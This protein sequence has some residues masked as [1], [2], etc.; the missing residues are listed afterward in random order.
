MERSRTRQIN[1]GIGAALA[2]LLLNAVVSYRNILRLMDNER[3]VSHTHLVLANLE[4]T[5]STLK[6]AET[7]QRGYLLTGNRQ[8]LDP[9]AAAITRVDQEVQILERLTADNS[10]QQQRIRDL[11]QAIDRK[12]ENLEAVITRYDSQGFLAAQQ[13]VQQ[14]RGKQLM[15]D[16]RQQ[17]AAMQAEENQLL[18]RRSQESQASARQTL[19][20]FSLASGLNLLLLALIFYLLRQDR[21]ERDREEAKQQQ[22]LT[23]LQAS[24]ARYRSLVSATS[25]AVWGT[26]A[27]GQVV[28]ELPSW[29]ALTGQSF[30]E[31]Q[32]S[33]WLRVLHPNDR[34]HSAQR[35]QHSLKTKTRYETEQRVRVAD[36]TYRLFQ[37]RGVPVLDREGE[38]REWVGTYTDITERKQAEAEIRQLNATLECRVEERT[39]QLQEA[40]AELEGFAYSVAHDLR[41]PLR[42]MQGL[43]EALLEDYGDR[44]DEMGQEYARQIVRSAEQLEDL[45]QDLLAYSRLSRMELQLEPVDLNAAVAESIAQATADADSQPA[46]III[47][48]P[49]PTVTA[50]R[51]TLIQVITNLL[52]NAI[53]FVNRQQPLVRVWAEAIEPPD[54][55]EGIHWVRLWVADNGIGIAPE[56]HKRIF[57]VFERL[58]GIEAY[59]G[60]GIGLAIVQ[61]GVERMGGEV[62]VE[63]QL[64][65]GS[66]FW[67][68]LRG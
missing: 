23:Q 8:F 46:Q 62:G 60:T 11:K 25:Q 44:L 65:Q 5:L 14:G 53:K 58:H 50:H 27:V 6:D 19:L 37:V 7:G 18:Q 59:P 48:S 51:T 31:V 61:K 47:A 22:L 2:L 9:Y 38:V 33:G 55:R 41:A 16:I 45:I 32:D 34:D 20:T 17:V 40:N 35:W 39:A 42:G 13:Q 63:S 66:R 43:S 3:R 30:A 12:L 36:G 67:I 64:A 24:E 15:D 1:I 10:Q 49:L 21:F 54:S 4:Q 57:R 26:N 56:Y 52:T 29:Q 28:E 68:T